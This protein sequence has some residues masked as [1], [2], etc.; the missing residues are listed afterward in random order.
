[1]LEL[2]KENVV[3]PLLTRV[4]SLTSGALV[5]MGAQQDHANW[6]ALGVLGGGLIIFDLTTA[7]LRKRNLV[8][9][10]AQSLILRNG[11]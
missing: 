2:I 10:A 5:A 9:K 8:N 11:G 4:G 1:M 7:Y 3:K 6:L